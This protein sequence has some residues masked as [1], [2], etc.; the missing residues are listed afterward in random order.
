MKVLLIRPNCEAD[1]IIPPFGLGYLATAI[2]D[3]YNVKILDGLKEGLT[4]EKL[5]SFLKENKFNFI[6][7]QVF[8]Y[9]IGAVRDYIKIIKE[10]SPLSAIILGGPHISCDPNN[11]FNYF[12]EVQFAFQGEAEIGFKKLLDLL[13]GEPSGN[14]NFFEVPGL[15]FKKEN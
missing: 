5:K 12:P 10:V 3:E 2:K 4:N 8:S 9:H 13:N 6:G 14:K 1:E 7:I 11:V 15:I